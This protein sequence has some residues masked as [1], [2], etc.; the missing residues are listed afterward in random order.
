[1]WGCAQ[2]A[3]WLLFCTALQMKQDGQVAKV[4]VFFPPELDPQ[5][6]NVGVDPC[7]L[8]IGLCKHLVPPPGVQMVVGGGGSVGAHANEEQL[9]FFPLS[10]P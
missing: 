4:C 1:M 6:V 8:L 10:F 7:E 2:L 3:G 5:P 9:W